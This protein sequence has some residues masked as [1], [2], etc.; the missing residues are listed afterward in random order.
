MK[1]L[2]ID[3][4]YLCH[5]AYHTTG[6][7]EYH[8]VYTG[9]IYGFL[10]QLYSIGKEIRP[11]EVVFAWDSKKS[12]RKNI[13]QNYKEKRSKD[14]DPFEWEEL[15]KAYKQFSQLRIKILPDLGFNNNFICSGYEAD[16]IIAKIVMENDSKNI[17]FSADGDLYQLLDY[18]D[19]YSI[20]K[21]GFKKM[22]KEVFKEEYKIE[23]KSWVKVKQIAGCNSDQVQGVVGVGEKTAIKYLTGVLKKDSVKCKAIESSKEIIQ[24]NEIL[25]KLPFPGVE[26]PKIKKSNFDIQALKKLAKELGFKKYKDY[27]FLENW[28]SFFKGE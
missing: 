11:D 7:L 14:I 15:Q 4:H 24:E 9:V 2:I 21:D 6:N 25:V 17:V 27:N 22:T 8:G 20:G 26:I 5:S 18:M 1:L 16:D 19:Q 23:P 13:R 3:S 12:L 10:N 28:K